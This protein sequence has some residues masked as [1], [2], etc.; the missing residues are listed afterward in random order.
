LFATVGD[1]TGTFSGNLRL[2]N[3]A[4]IVAGDDVTLTFTGTD[5]S[6]YLNDSASYPYSSYIQASPN[7][8]HLDFTNRTSGGIFIDGVESTTSV[9]GGSGFFVTNHSTPA[10]SG[11]GLDIKHKEVVASVDTCTVNPSLCSSTPTTPTAPSTPDTPPPPATP[12]TGGSG[13]GIPSVPG[14]TIG[15]DSGQFGG[16]TD[17]SGGSGSGSSSSSGSG[18][19]GSSSSGGSSASNENKDGDKKDEKKDDKK[20]SAD[21]KD[22]KKDDKASKKPVAQCKA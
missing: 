8:I 5:S 12:G 19:S 18:D 21:A 16:T 22:D 2:N 1:V 11:A 15:G 13:S 17:T 4:E 10:T 3:G 14:Q 6:L 9:S 7:T 20:K